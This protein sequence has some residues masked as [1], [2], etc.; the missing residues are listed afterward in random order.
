M[1]Y[2]IPTMLA[3]IAR[4]ATNVEE[5]IRRAEAWASTEARHP[6]DSELVALWNVKRAGDARQRCTLKMLRA[7]R[8]AR[9]TGRILMR[10]SLLKEVV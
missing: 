4:E 5:Y 1:R 2:K 10:E 9:E 3:I 7:A 6:S 8:E